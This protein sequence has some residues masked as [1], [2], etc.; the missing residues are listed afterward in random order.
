LAGRWLV[1][2][3]YYLLLGIKNSGVLTRFLGFSYLGSFDG[4][5]MSSGSHQVIGTVIVC[6]SDKL[7]ATQQNELAE[8]IIA[9]LIELR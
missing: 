4:T 7:T 2:K 8:Q 9:N 6:T 5:V 3:N 1:L